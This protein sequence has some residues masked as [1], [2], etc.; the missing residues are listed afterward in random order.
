MY[1]G[2]LIVKNGTIVLPEGMFKFDIVIEDGRIV[3]IG[4]D[5]PIRTG[6]EIID[7]K[8][9][10]ILPGIVDEHVHM[11]EPGLEYKDDFTHGTMAAAAGGVTTVLEMP[12]T[13]PPVD[14]GAR[15]KE[16]A[17]LLSSKAYVDFALYGVLHDGNVD[18]FE[19]IIDEG[20]IGFKVFLGP[21][22]GNIPAP[23]DSSIYE[24]LLKS[25]KYNVPIAFHAENWSL[26][27]YFTEKVKASGRM[28]PR[29]HLDSR[30]PI[31]E[32]E[33]IQR[34]I[35]YS[36]KTKG[37][38]LI[39]HMSSR[40]GVELLKMA[41]SEGINVYGETCPHYLL[42]SANDYDKYGALIKVNPPIREE[43]HRKSLWEA[44]INDI[45][46]HLGSDHAPHAEKEKLNKDI[47]GAAAG[48]IGVQTFLPLMLDAAL[49][50]KIPL[51]K[52]PELMSRNPSR[53]FN[54]YPRKGT[55]SIG[56]DGDLVIVDP[57]EEYVIKREDIYA[58]HP[59]TPFIGWK[60]KGRIKY[61]VVRGIVVAKDGKIVI[62]KPVGIWVKRGSTVTNTI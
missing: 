59:I 54:L 2:N 17:S 39:V 11:R 10:L 21:T 46:T 34:L 7:A 37:K 48:F 29:A 42:I 62:S 50:G 61:T 8:G 33:A 60:L 56:S 30:P 5:I 27:K 25:A 55:I 38:V 49:R 20:A 4:K 44:I 16:K 6:F 47:W 31:C 22:T 41:R 36:K 24:I 51:T 57:N 35:L 3:E 23:S 18:K 13:L 15:V 53:L 58:K 1:G 45:I 32:E 19:D 26:I 12:N 40:E 14:S 43:H 9:M 28:D 52:I